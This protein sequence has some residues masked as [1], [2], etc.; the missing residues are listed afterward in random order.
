MAASFGE[1]LL[2]WERFKIRLLSFPVIHDFWQAIWCNKVI[3]LTIK[4]H[5]EL[6]SFFENSL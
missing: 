4:I 5:G 3:T 1:F 6:Y 2:T